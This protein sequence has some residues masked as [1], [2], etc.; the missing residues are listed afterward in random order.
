VR[1]VKILT[2][3]QSLT[4]DEPS[5]DRLECLLD[6][7]DKG[8]SEDIHRF[9]LCFERAAHGVFFMPGI[10]WKREFEKRIGGFLKACDIRLETGNQGAP[11]Q[12]DREYPRPKAKGRG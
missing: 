9:T 4:L 8:I 3:G 11:S 1:Q 5:A 10:Y 12:H 7:A 6:K 2:E